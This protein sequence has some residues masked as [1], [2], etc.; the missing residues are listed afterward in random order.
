MSELSALWFISLLAKAMSVISPMEVSLL[1]PIHAAPASPSVPKLLTHAHGT[2]QKDNRA[3]DLVL[4]LQRV[5]MRSS[6]G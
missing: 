3:P 2:L 6:E 5:G 4:V 1:R